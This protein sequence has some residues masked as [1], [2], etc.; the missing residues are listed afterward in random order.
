[1]RIHELI[2]EAEANTPASQEINQTLINAGYTKL[3]AGNDSTVWK[4]NAGNIIKII[5]PDPS[6]RSRDD[7]NDSFIDFYNY[8][9]S[10]KKN[11]HLPRFVT[12]QGQ[13]YS[14]FNING[15][16]YMQIAME[17]LQPIVSNQDNIILDWLTGDSLPFTKS[18]EEELK[19][20]EGDWEDIDTG[21]IFDPVKLTKRYRDLYNTAKD[22]RA[23]TSRM[24]DLHPGNI[25]LRGNTL[26]IIDPWY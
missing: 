7:A 22:M 25:M 9:Q 13:S 5:M 3:G 23:R 24:W 26:V 10:H 1:M 6:D 19:T 12:I 17:H 8:V 4:K 15:H 2:K 18:W 21:T 16:T 20:L 14:K 11:P